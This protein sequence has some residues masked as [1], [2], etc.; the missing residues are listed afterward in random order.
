MTKR[1]LSVFFFLLLPFAVFVQCQNEFSEKQNGVIS[2]A[3]SSETQREEK[4]YSDATIENDF[5]GSSVI[6]VM[7]KKTG[8]MNKR[9][10]PNFFRGFEKEYVEDLTEITVDPKDALIDWEKFHQIL[11][12]KLPQ[13]S[14]EN[15]LNVIRQLE[16]TE[17]ILYAGPNYF[18]YPTAVPDD[19]YYGSQWGLGESQG[20]NAPAAWDITLGSN[21]AAV[22]VR[23]GIIDTGIAPHPDLNANLVA[24]KNFV[25]GGNADDTNDT[26]GHGTLCAGIAG[27][28]GKNNTGISGVCWNVNLV[29]LKIGDTTT[30]NSS[31]SGSII[32]AINYAKTSNI[33]ILNFSWSSSDNDL[34]VRDAIAC[35]SGLFVCPAGNGTNNNGIGKNND[36]I[37]TR[38]YPAD[39]TADR[40]PAYPTLTN[41]ISVGS[42]DN[43]GSQSS[44]SNWGER[45]VDLFA[46]GGE[47]LSTY[48][49]SLYD[50]SNPSTHP[51]RGYYKTGG[52]S[53]AAPHVAGVAALIYSLHPWMGGKELKTALRASVDD[54][55]QTGLC[56]TNGKINAY[57]AVNY[58]PIVGSMNIRFNGPNL[59]TVQ[60]TTV[61][62]IPLGKFHLF[63]NN[64][65][66]I[67][68]MGGALST[69]INNFGPNDIPVYVNW[70]PV[71]P[72]ITN[73]LRQAGVGRISPMFLRVYV[74]LSRN[75]NEYQY[76]NHSIMPIITSTGST[77]VN[78]VGRAY[79]DETLL[80]TDQRK[81]RIQNA[82]GT[83]Y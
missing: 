3:A 22:G 10:D 55:P 51:A 11:M 69:P 82:Y 57:K 74:P 39:W 59:R 38:E 1:I 62:T 81:I 83:L 46:P 34:G 76:W 12:I 71:P 79:I 5:D 19:T 42:I 13:D 70:E 17:G 56:S 48:P 54:L 44:F 25:A 77:V 4:I 65:W 47:I 31:T 9:H 21:D 33:P 40:P 41:L 64:K 52:T 36:N 35:Y 75:S 24:G 6:V 20:I 43:N 37:N 50:P 63:T 7:D 61:G 53:Y 68:E 8:G 72:A 73:Y 58:I 16:K 49:E 14:K 45:T 28:V 26:D 29:P 27:G 15:I 78:D 30:G 80:P 60:G 32:H 66:A 18:W 2:R 67:V 23:V